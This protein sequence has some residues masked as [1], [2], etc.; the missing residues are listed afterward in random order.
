MEPHNPN[1]KV[2]SN[3]EKSNLTLDLPPFLVPLILWLF[4][5]FPKWPEIR[6]SIFP[7]ESAEDRPD[8]CARVFQIKKQE[9]I[10]DLIEMNALGHSIGWIHVKE[11]QKRGLPVSSEN[12]ICFIRISWRQDK[13]E[14]R[15]YYVTFSSFT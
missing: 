9:L 15:W 11:D 3:Q 5:M 4:I 8:I 7:G 13:I 14:Y 1:F 6:S 2:Y 10:H 12:S